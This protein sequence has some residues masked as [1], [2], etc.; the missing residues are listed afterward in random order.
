MVYASTLQRWA[1]LS[2]PYQMAGLL[3]TVLAKT[4]VRGKGV[5][6][7]KRNAVRTGALH[8]EGKALKGAKKVPSL[9]TST[10]PEYIIA[11]EGFMNELL[12][13]IPARKQDTH[14]LYP[15]RIF[16]S[17]Q[18]I[19]YDHL[20]APGQPSAYTYLWLYRGLSDARR[21]LWI[22]SERYSVS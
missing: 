1:Y 15:S 3:T 19:G 6:N 8:N 16:H 12:P 9:R 11:T 18:T 4:L 22:L 14:L 17:R 7:W 10:V 21:R 20:R 13:S 2:L 5:F